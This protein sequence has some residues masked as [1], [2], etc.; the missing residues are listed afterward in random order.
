MICAPVSVFFSTSVPHSDSVVL[1]VQ[2]VRASSAVRFLSVR[3]PDVTP[4][5]AAKA[6]VDRCMWLHAVG[7]E[8]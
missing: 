6:A 2:T 5:A 8:R 1:C 7:T 3:F 4:A